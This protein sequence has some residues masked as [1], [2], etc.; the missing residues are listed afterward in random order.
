VKSIDWTKIFVN[1]LV[2]E[3]IYVG[4][5]Q[6]DP[7]DDFA[8]ALGVLKAGGSYVPLDP[9]M[10][11]PRLEI[12]SAGLR[13][14]AMQA[15]KIGSSKGGNPALIGFA[16]ALR[17]GLYDRTELDHTRFLSHMSRAK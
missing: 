16:P 17:L 8:A 14:L 6:V 5:L 9:E 13:A 11:M 2:I 3:V 15:R 12:R 7:A 1:M 10:P 4:F